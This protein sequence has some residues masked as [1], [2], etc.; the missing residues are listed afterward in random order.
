M[1]RMITPA[2]TTMNAVSV[3][4]DTISASR[5]NG[6]T[7][8]ST[9]TAN[10][11]I[12]VLRTGVFVR[13]FT[14]AKVAGS[15]PS[16]PIVNRIRVWPY[17]VT[18]VTE[19]IEITAPAATMVLPAVLPVM[20]S[21]ITASTASSPLK[22]CHRCAPMAATETSRWIAVTISRAAMIARGMVCC[23]SFTSSPAVDI[24][25]R[26]IYA[27]KIVPEARL[28]PDTPKGA[29]S[30]KL[31]ALNSVNA[32]A[33]NNTSTLSLITTITAFALADSLAP[34]I[35][36]SAHIATSA[37]ASRF[38]T[39]GSG[40]HGAAETACGR[41]KPKTLSRNL[42]RYWL[43]PTATAAVDTPYSSSKQAATP[44]AANSP[45]VA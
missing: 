31:P 18:S 4:I 34:R 16:R 35:N 17:N 41:T 36:S 33:E 26:P 45:S 43:Q 19:N 28:M 1:R 6:T 27:K 22:S 3:P 7:A 44:I 9:A 13:G 8:A 21:K 38:T 40:S 14:F 5:S 23:G 24:A 37:I 30:L 42:L 12:M 20:W 2:D 32:I 15:S 11:T 10:A 39:P 29:R 25:S